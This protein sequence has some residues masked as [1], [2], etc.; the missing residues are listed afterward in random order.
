MYIIVPQFRCYLL[1]FSKLF[2]KGRGVVLMLCQILQLTL[3]IQIAGFGVEIFYL[4]NTEQPSKLLKK[5]V[6]KIQSLQI[7]VFASG[8][9]FHDRE[10]RILVQVIVLNLIMKNQGRI[11]NWIFNDNL[12]IWKDFVEM[13]LQ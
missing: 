13:Q 11:I 6:K 8:I 1:R 2:F 3:Y 12:C 9:L 4:E 7:A 5:V 10:E